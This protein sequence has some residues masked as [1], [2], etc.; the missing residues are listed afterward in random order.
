MEDLATFEI[1]KKLKDIGFDW[2]CS[3]YYRIK[4]KKLFMIFPSEDWSYIEDRINAPTISQALKW[5]RDVKNIHIEIYTNASGYNYIIS[6]TPKLGGSDRY[7]SDHEG[8]NDGGCWDLYEECAIA[9]I[10]RILF[11]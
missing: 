8:P 6:D 11:K 4:D 2:I 9:A 7:W 1:S 10:E 5:F 3:H